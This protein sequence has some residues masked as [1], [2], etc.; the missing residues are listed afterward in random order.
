[1]FC[2]VIRY[3]QTVISK[4]CKFEL[5]S[6][7][8]PSMEFDGLHAL[9][10]AVD[11][12]EKLSATIPDTRAGHDATASSSLH[13]HTTPAVQTEREKRKMATR[14]RQFEQMQQK[15]LMRK[16]KTRA[17][18]RLTTER[19][20]DLLGKIIWKEFKGNMYQGEVVSVSWVKKGRAVYDFGKGVTSTRKYFVE[21]SDGDSEDMSES[22]VLQYMV[23]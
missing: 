13:K 6:D 17:S 22:Q 8:A 1:M 18:Q 16:T 9:V 20:H 19:M 5:C 21:Y 3:L 15:E 2:S 14:I 10:S 23:A 7:V 12:L 4:L 11:L